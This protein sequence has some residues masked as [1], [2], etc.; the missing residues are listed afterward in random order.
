[1]LVQWGS[2]MRMVLSSLF[3]PFAADPLRV[4]SKSL[5]SPKRHARWRAAGGGCQVVVGGEQQGEQRI[6]DDECRGRNEKQRNHEHGGSSVGVCGFSY[7]RRGSPRINRDL[8]AR[9]L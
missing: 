3:A 2:A 6:A 9:Y 5:P 4:T 1:M 8:P 7:G